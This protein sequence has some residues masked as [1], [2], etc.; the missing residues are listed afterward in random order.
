[1]KKHKLPLRRHTLSNGR[2]ITIEWDKSIKGL[3][4]ED[5]RRMT[6]WEDKNIKEH[7]NT[8]LHELIHAE[9]PKFSEIKTKKIASSFSRI[10]LKTY[11]ITRKRT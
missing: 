2:R 4:E 3:W 9:F 5:I 11:R 6:I 10:I 7:V 8:V 1:M